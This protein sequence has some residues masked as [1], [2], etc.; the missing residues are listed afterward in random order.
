[1]NEDFAAVVLAAGKGTR[2]NSRKINKVM[3]Q[4]AGKPMIS[5]TIELLEKAGLKK[6]I[7]VVGF[8]AKSVQDYLGPKYIYAVQKKR[9][10]TGNALKCGLKK[11][12]KGIKNI[13]VC[14][15]DDTAFYPA[16]VIKKLMKKHLANNNELTLLTAVKK[17]PTG[18]GRVVRDK[19]NRAVAVVE[20]KNTTLSQKKIKEINTGCYCFRLAFINKF[21]PEIKRDKLK[22]E[23]YLTDIL[24]IAAE[25]RQ[26]VQALRLSKGEHFQ[27]IN[28]KEE[29]IKADLLMRKRKKSE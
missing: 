4:L 21:L 18:L 6:I 2:L 11:V 9:L 28:T 13:F 26:K 22:K 29:L 14:S 25:T 16:I 1:M 23:Y 17:N 3:Y 8:A 27:G 15:S 5:Y 10:G 24:A 12:P 7:I 20:E 19:E